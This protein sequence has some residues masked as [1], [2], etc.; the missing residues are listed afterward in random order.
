MIELEL[1]DFD[2][3]KI[4]RSGQCFRF[5]PLPEGGGYAL[6]ALGR[7]LEIRQQGGRVRFGC[8]PQE[9]EAV[10]RAYF[11]LDADY[12]ALCAAIDPRDSYLQAAAR[13]A[14]GVRILRQD[15]WE[16]ILA[17]I[18]S[19][20]NNIPRIQKC[21]EALC[22]AYGQPF[23]NSRGEVYWAVPAPEVLAAADESALRGL[24]LG[25]RAR[26]VRT[27]AQQVACGQVDLKALAGLPYEQARGKLL[28]LCGVGV[29]VAECVCLFGLHHVDAFPIDTHIKQMLAA[30]YGQGFPLQRYKG[31]AGILQQYAFYYELYGEDGA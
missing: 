24:G 18:L 25:Y 23:E 9:F 5:R 26:Y 7:Y 31:F 12:G 30:H 13:C 2:I 1:K 10:W 8:G 27:A 21:L 15:V 20:Q 19:Q 11:D 3:A 17:F 14:A 6:A 16:T 28:E 22:T 29:K 4:A